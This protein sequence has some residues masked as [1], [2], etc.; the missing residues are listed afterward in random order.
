[1]KEFVLRC[2]RKCRSYAALALFALTGSAALAEGESST[3]APDFT[4]A[5]SAI[6][7]VSEGIVTWVKETVMGKI[8]A[9]AVAFVVVRLVVWVI[10]WFARR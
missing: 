1:M 10:K 7:A 5:T 2:F 9:V 4:E 8:I 3:Y 6:T